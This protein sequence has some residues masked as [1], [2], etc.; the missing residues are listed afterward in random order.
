LKPRFPLRACGRLL[1]ASSLTAFLG[2]NASAATLTGTVINRTTNQPSAGADVFLLA[3]SQGMSEVDSTKTDAQGRFRFNVSD[4]NVPHLIRVNYQ[5]VN[6]FS[7][8]GPIPPGTPSVEVDV[9]DS[10]A[11]LEGVKTTIQAMRLQTSGS[12]LEV[13]ELY[14]VQNASNPPRALMSD[15]TYTVN[16]PEGAEIQ[17][18][19]ASG[20]GGMP[21]AAQPSPGGQPGQYYFSFPLRP[22]ETRFQIAY[23]LGYGGEATIRP[24]PASNLEHFAVL[25]PSS[26]KFESLNPGVYSPMPS[27]DGGSLVQVAT[28]VKSGQDI[29]FRIS[30]TGTIGEPGE[31]A[32]ANGPR[33]GGGLGTP[34]G[35]PD[36]LQ[37]YRWG[38]LAALTA[39]LALGGVYTAK[40]S[41]KPAPAGAT[42]KIPAASRQQILLDALKEEL[43]QLELDRQQGRITPEEYAKSK[44]ALDETLHRATTRRQ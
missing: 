1:L 7:K 24:R 36:P 2:L 23:R 18:A 38:I 22:G 32:Q 41:A 30:G 6:Y 43:F 44:S 17:Q 8:G 27:Q 16:L 34:E 19:S 9:Y 11:S 12:F 13:T 39:L 29:A 31:Q 33:P 20:P 10:A 14:A 26:M 42:L 35:T 28:G 5:G 15:R 3:L 4:D 25:M 21:I 40:R 37:R